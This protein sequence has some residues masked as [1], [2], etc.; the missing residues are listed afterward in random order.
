MSAPNEW[1]KAVEHPERHY[2]RAEGDDMG[3]ILFR[4][5]SKCWLGEK[6]GWVVML[7]AG[8]AERVIS[9][10]LRFDVARDGMTLVPITHRAETSRRD[11]DQLIAPFLERPIPPP[12]NLRGP[13]ICFDGTTCGLCLDDHEPGIEWQQGNTPPEWEWLDMAHGELTGALARLHSE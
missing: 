13:H 2:P 10:Q 6:F 8:N 3:G 1:S 12:G 7:K 4:V 11:I 9:I 5:W